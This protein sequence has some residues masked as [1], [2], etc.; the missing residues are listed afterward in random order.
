M[1][2]SRKARHSSGKRHQNQPT[3]LP[4]VEETIKAEAEKGDLHSQ[5]R[6]GAGRGNIPSSINACVEQ[7]QSGESMKKEC[8][9]LTLAELCGQPESI[10]V[11]RELR[12]TRHVAPLVLDPEESV[13]AA[14]VATLSAM[15][16][17]GKPE[18]GDD[19]TER[20]V[21]DDVMT[22][23][24][25]LFKQYYP[26]GW[27]PD[28]SSK[29]KDVFVS[30]VGLIRSLC[31]SS[32]TALEVFNRENVIYSIITATDL[33]QYS[34]PV[35]AAVC[36]CLLTVTEANPPAMQSVKQD[37]D[38]MRNLQLMA[39]TLPE[40]CLL[41][42]TDF[43]SLLTSVVVA[44]ILLNLSDG[45]FGAILPPVLSA[46]L[47]LI[48]Y[49]LKIDVESCVAQLK[50]LAPP[51]GNVKA[52]Q[53]DIDEA[54][55]MEEDG[56]NGKSNGDAEGLRGDEGAEEELTGDS[57]ECNEDDTAD[58]LPKKHR[59]K[60]VER[61]S[62]LLTA[63]QMALEM[64]TNICSAA[65]DDW[66]EDDD[67]DNSSTCSDGL[68]ESSCSG[69]N[70]ATE[71][72]ASLTLPC[73]VRDALVSS[74]IISTIVRCCGSSFS[75][76]RMGLDDLLD[77]AQARLLSTK[78]RLVQT[79]A[80]TAI[81]N[82]VASDV[83]SLGG[84][85]DLV[86]L[87][88]ELSSLLAVIV[89]NDSEAKDLLEATTCA[90]RAVVTKIVALDKSS[91]PSSRPRLFAPT[92]RDVQVLVDI[93][94]SACNAGSDV[95][96]IDNRSVKI[97][98]VRIS[99]S[100]AASAHVK[101]DS[102]DTFSTIGS[103][104]LSASVDDDVAVSGEALD[105]IFDVF[106]DD[107]DDCGDNMKIV[108]IEIRLIERLR[109]LIPGFQEKVRLQRKRLGPEQKAVVQTVKTNLLPFIKYKTQSKG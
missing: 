96:K 62:D 28:S 75:Q 109:N 27:T 49:V 103:F 30:A 93:Y 108:E 95:D 25:A 58:I 24:V 39:Q 67:G 21:Q 70:L 7:L 36:E 51:D 64:L 88:T 5:G 65:D 77:L 14:A 31:E 50:R 92:Q 68:M 46:I 107:D 33:K 17:G 2:K 32:P 48:P 19:V 22:P 38:T 94:K 90:L 60:T 52:Q 10:P 83:T 4:S 57:E 1:G 20:M 69:E 3:G 78:M 85:E 45:D 6:L 82:L 43:K 63:Q 99:S 106:G 79:R 53:G 54:M 97:N 76:S 16:S 74:E 86:N 13:R 89:A 55:V 12:L 9:L 98:V 81:N 18:D 84:I 8:G 26:A 11:F 91:S 105:A 59:S 35:V 102:R 29:S 100:L 101:L 47:T 56:M 41:E 40:D 37:A 104:L 61:L 71:D 87:F 34:L 72:C 15:T 73:E 23:V 66:E 80:L 42:T 44:G